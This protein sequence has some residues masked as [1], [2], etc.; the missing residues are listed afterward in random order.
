MG[1]E[2][3]EDDEQ[4]KGEKPQRKSDVKEGLTV[5]I[6]NLSFNSSEQSVASLFKQ[7]GSIVYCKL[8]VNQFT[9]QN[10]GTAFVKFRDSESVTSCLAK[11]EEEGD[12]GGNE[13][14]PVDQSP[15]CTESRVNF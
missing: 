14:G 9:E 6:R 3:A 12:G 2:N 7:F 11:A 5:F 1:S 4:D 13:L 8:V 15:V 10:R